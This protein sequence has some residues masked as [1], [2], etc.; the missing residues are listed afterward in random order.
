MEKVP[1]NCFLCS[2]KVPQTLSSPLTGKFVG[3]EDCPLLEHELERLFI[4]RYLLDI[5]SSFC[6][7]IL[8]VD[9]TGQATESSW[10]AICS[11]C[12]AEK[13][14]IAWEIHQQSLVLEGKM[15]RLKKRIK[16]E[17]K[18]KVIRKGIICRENRIEHKIWDYLFPEDG[19]QGRIMTEANVKVELT[20]E[21]YNPDPIFD[22]SFPLD[23]CYSEPDADFPIRRKRG[24][25][26]GRKNNSSFLKKSEARQKVKRKRGRPRRSES[27]AV[28]VAGSETSTGAVIKTEGSSAGD[29]DKEV[30]ATKAFTS[31][32]S[33]QLNN[34]P[35]LKRKRGRPKRVESLDGDG[36]PKKKI[37]KPGAA[38]EFYKT[39]DGKLKRKSFHWIICPLCRAKFRHS[40]EFQSHKVAHQLS[41]ENGGKFDCDLCSF[42]A[43]DLNDLERH[44]RVRHLNGVKSFKKVHHCSICNSFSTK[45]WKFLKV[46]Y[47]QEH[48]AL[49][50]EL[51][52]VCELCSKS[53]VTFQALSF[54][55]GREH[56]EEPQGEGKIEQPPEIVS[57]EQCSMKFPNRASL[58]LHLNCT[59]DRQNR[60]ICSE[61]GKGF[62]YLKSLEQHSVTHE[63]G[64]RDFVCHLCGCDYPVERTLLAHYR[65]VHQ[66]EMADGGDG[67][68]EFKCKYCELTSPFKVV[69]IRHL[70]T[71]KK[72]LGHQ[73]QICQKLYFNAQGLKRHMRFNHPVTD[74]KVECP[75]CKKVFSNMEYMKGHVRQYCKLKN[76]QG[77]SDEAGEADTAAGVGSEQMKLE[78]G[79]ASFSN[80]HVK[81]F[82]TS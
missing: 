54:H 23:V 22:D 25:P 41:L 75:Y 32:A 78:T 34:L 47:E 53:F 39:R 67:D 40:E 13:V 63:M 72:E 51:K 79:T 2:N 30:A 16:E 42:P 8:S 12:Y 36:I 46:H 9:D 19:N 28:P 33:S 74:E 45:T 11:D 55:M 6:E 70:A 60:H 26:K 65:N 31:E 59:H 48:P 37:R 68:N 3:C 80:A 35:S 81:N 66:T 38:S 62:Q 27:G 76:L 61:C 69:I 44:R 52:A 29:D 82:Y 18:G 7:N 4:L 49:A 64:R 17:M 1:R 58:L 77:T 73:C 71:H 20:E 21:N 57:C 15:R 10:G 43:T 5:P 56:C 50:D 24:R 14:L